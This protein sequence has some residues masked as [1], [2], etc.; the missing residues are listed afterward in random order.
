MILYMYPNPAATLTKLQRPKKSTCK[1][2]NTCPRT[3]F[4]FYE[5]RNHEENLSHDAST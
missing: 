5:V 1:M 2:L 4:N 3:V